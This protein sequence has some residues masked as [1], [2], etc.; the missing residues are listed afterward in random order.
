M[1]FKKSRVEAPVFNEPSINNYYK[2][3]QTVLYVA[4][5]QGFDADF[6]VGVEQVDDSL[7]NGHKS[8]LFYIQIMHYGTKL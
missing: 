5:M 4:P 3:A 7:S 6:D 2:F 1:P 8:D